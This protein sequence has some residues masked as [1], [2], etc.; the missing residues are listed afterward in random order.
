MHNTRAVLLEPQEVSVY[1]RPGVPE[2]ISL[3]I[4]TAPGHPTP[5][6]IMDRSNAPAEVNVTLSNIVTD[7]PR[8]LQV[9]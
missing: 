1:L 5:E 7:N 6:L 9:R 8:N 4:S 2:V 3:T